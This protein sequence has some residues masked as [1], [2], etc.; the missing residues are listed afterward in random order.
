MRDSAL[1][2]VMSQWAVREPGAA[3]TYVEEAELSDTQRELY[4][5]FLR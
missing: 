4:R 5:A 1:G 3:R 2:S